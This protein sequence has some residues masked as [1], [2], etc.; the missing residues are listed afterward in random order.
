MGGSP[1]GEEP[2]EVVIPVEA[3]LPE[4]GDIAAY[5]ETTSRVEA[6]NYVDVVPESVERCIS[7]HVEEGDRV[8]EG[9][10]LAELDKSQLQTQIDETRTQLARQRADLERAKQAWEEGIGARVE[11]ENAKFAYEQTEAQIERLRLQLGNLTIRAPLTG[12]VTMRNIQPGQVVSTGSAVFRIVDPKSYILTIDVPEQE[13]GELHEGQIAKVM[14]DSIQGE[15]FQARVRRIAPNVDPQSHMVKATLDFDSATVARLRDQ[16]FARV[17]L[18]LET[19][20]NVLLVPKDAVQEEKNRRYLFVLARESEKSPSA[21]A[22]ADGES[23]GNVFVAERVEIETGLEDSNRT[24]VVSGVE[25]TTMVITLGHQNLKTGSL[26]RVT[27]A[28]AELFANAD[29][30]AEEALEAAEKA[31]QEGAKEVQRQPRGL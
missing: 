10:V 18:V 5:Y 19:H 20:E 28:E 2:E 27:D 16:A 23:K 8:Q 17:R 25:A 6:E 29:M 15:T 3:Q 13:V 30:S 7:V 24:E 1:G 22:G 14:L 9:D 26:V 21:D 4:R 31:R 11:Y 12:I